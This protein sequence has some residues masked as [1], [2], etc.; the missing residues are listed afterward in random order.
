[1]LV[2]GSC[3]ESLAQRANVT[4]KFTNESPRVVS[5]RRMSAANGATVQ[6]IPPGASRS[7]LSVP[8]EQ[9]EI[10]SGGS[11]IS[12]YQ[13]TAKGKQK[14]SI[15][16]AGGNNPAP[17][18]GPVSAPVPGPAVAGETGS[19]ATAAEARQ[20]L[21]YHNQKRQEVGSPNL[22]WSAEI[23]RFAQ[24]RADTIART[25]RFAHLPQGQNPYGENLAQGGSSGGGPGYTVGS[26]CDGWF[27]EKQQMPAGA[28]VMSVAL[29]NRG[30]GHYTQMVWKGSTGIGAGIAHFQQ[31][32]FNMTVVVCCY[33]PPGNQIGVPVY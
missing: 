3:D 7:E 24:G 30:V 5:L 29:F 6:E 31:N 11:Q 14:F 1:M 22:S 25:K 17:V 20:I 21:D 33:N 13:A 32:G 19:Q 12:Q 28:P 15:R 4:I 27:A 26:A 9:W 23:A 16:G 18:P 2:A 8:G 10:L